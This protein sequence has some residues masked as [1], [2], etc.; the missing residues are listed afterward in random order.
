M[1][2][3]NLPSVPFILRVAASFVGIA[4]VS[5]AFAASPAKP[6]PALVSEIGIT[7]FD[8]EAFRRLVK[9][10]VGT[11]E[12]KFFYTFG[13]VRA[14]PGGEVLFYYEGVETCRENPMTTTATSATQISRRIFFYRDA[15]TGEYIRSFN[16]TP[17]PPVAYP[18]LI[19][20]WNLDPEGKVQIKG[21]QGQE[22]RVV[23]MDIEV[24]TV[25]RLPN[26]VL[27][28]PVNLYFQ[29]G[30]YSFHE[31]GNYVSDPRELNGRSFESG[32]FARIQPMPGW[33]AKSYGAANVVLDLSVVEVG[34]FQQL[35]AR[36][37]SILS[38]EFPLYTKPPKDLEECIRI[39]KGQQ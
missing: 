6:A 25:R 34:G 19:M 36:L 37:Q 9:F 22:P 23:S 32:H 2:G 31:M 21:T 18:Y 24:P 11:G 3:K 27:H 28:F 30:A 5:G 12:E 20:Q 15:K 17:V 10:R 7:R 35:P 14:H 4:A 1:F 8:A 38:D 33:A 29:A 39:Q 16:G 26:D 13:D